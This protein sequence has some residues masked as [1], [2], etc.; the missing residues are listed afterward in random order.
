MGSDELTSAYLHRSSAL[1]SIALAEKL[2]HIPSSGYSLSKAALN[3]LTAQYAAALAD[4][5]FTVI[6]L[7][8]G[9]SYNQ[10]EIR[11][12]THTHI[13]YTPSPSPSP[14]RTHFDLPH[15]SLR[16]IRITT[17]IRRVYSG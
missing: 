7:S 6:S 15:Q 8:P 1:G 9:V 5:G 2:Q 12:N 16:S 11:T 17:N 13:H 14:S 10:Y 3:M 4:S